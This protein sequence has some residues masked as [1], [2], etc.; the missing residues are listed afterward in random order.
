MSHSS[1]ID[2]ARIRTEI[3]REVVSELV[4]DLKSQHDLF[5]SLFYA[6]FASAIAVFIVLFFSYRGDIITALWMM[7]IGSVVSGRIEIAVPV[8]ATILILALFQFFGYSST[9]TIVLAS[10]SVGEWLQQ[11]NISRV[12][13]MSYAKDSRFQR[14]PPIPSV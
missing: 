4:N 6:L 14:K 2:R 7:F 12:K 3:A 8:Y 9:E 10:E 11:C 13:N 5:R 1:A